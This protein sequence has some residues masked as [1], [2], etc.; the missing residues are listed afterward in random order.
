MAKHRRAMLRWPHALIACLAAIA[1]SPSPAALGQLPAIVNEPPPD[2]PLQT[3][4]ARLEVIES[5]LQ[6][7]LDADEKRT[8]N[9]PQRPTFQLGGL[10]HL[11][12]LFIGQ[13]AANR[14]TV[15]DAEDVFGF[16]RARL[17]ARGEAY[18]VVNYAIGFD[19]ALDGRPSF[20]DNYV[21]ISE[22]PL[23]GN[24]RAGHFFEPFSLERFTQI[25][26]V[27]FMERS[28]A[29]ALAPARNLGIM[30]HDT[31]GA[32]DHGTWAIGWFRS[33]SDVFGD[34][35][36]DVGGWAV[37]SRVTWLPHYDETNGGRSFVHLG[38]AY[39]FRSEA[40]RE[41]RFSSFPEA[42]AGE[43]NTTGI[44]PFV[45]TGTIAAVSQQRLG[46]EWALVHGPFTAQ[47]EYIFSSVDQ[48]G[49]PPLFFHGAYAYVSYFLTGE[50][51]TYNKQLGIMDRVYPHENFF[52]VR[53][54]EGIQT[55]RGAWEIA[56]RWS[57][58]D[59]DDANIRGGTLN[60][61]TIGLNWHLNP[62]TR[63]KWEYVRAHLD[64]A[65]VGDSLAHI[66]GMRFDIDF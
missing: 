15:G 32:L 58:L 17:T 44:P 20:L 8:S 39:S 33:N 21:A 50:N 6:Q 43:T 16:R 64:R 22:L 52:R 49:G 3:D 66:F 35:F 45:D 12:Y 42:R 29:D 55:G 65:P 63:I 47:A 27:T 57:F 9:A 54:D 53:T 38:A 48:T 5:Q 61:I 24:V 19:F 51:R 7:L 41:I 25:R 31:V 23:L 36:G 1:L 59:L 14:A 18:E 2:A 11:D 62:H 10:L 56:A 13:D 30:A 4:D 40:Q 26:Y 60:D 34:D 28:L 46:A 37:T